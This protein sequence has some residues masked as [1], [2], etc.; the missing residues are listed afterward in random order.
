MQWAQLTATLVAL[1]TICSILEKQ[2]Q[3][4]AFPTLRTYRGVSP[5]KAL[6]EGGLYPAEDEN[7]PMVMNPREKR[8]P[9]ENWDPRCEWSGV[10]ARS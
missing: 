6:S 8:H 10:E 2:Q 3:V 1:F 4:A 5:Y 9:R 7:P